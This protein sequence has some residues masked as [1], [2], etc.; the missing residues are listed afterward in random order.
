MRGFFLCTLIVSLFAP[1]FAQTK[2][3]F[4]FED[5]MKLKRVGEPEVSPD[6]KWVLFSVVDVDLDANTQ[7]PHIWIVPTG[8]GQEREIIA[9]QDAD[10]PRW[11]PDGKRFAFISNKEGGSQ[12]WIAD[13][14]AGAGTVTGLHKLTSI[15]T[16][17]DGELWS[18]D[19]KNILFVSNIYPD[20]PDEACNARKLEEAAK[21]KVKAI[22]FTRLLF[23]HLYAYKEG[24]RSHIFVIAV[25]ACAGTGAPFCPADAARDLTPGDYDA[26]VFSF[27]QDEYAFSPDGREICYTSNHDKNE[28]ASTNSDLWIV[29]IDATVI[30]SGQTVYRQ[31]PQAKNITADNLASDS[32]PL[33]SPDGRYI[34]YRAQQRPGYESDRLRLTL[35]DRKTGEKKN[36]TDDFDRWVGTFA[37]APDSKAIYFTAEDKGDSPV[38]RVSLETPNVV[39]RIV[40]LAGR[41]D[42]PGLASDGKSL[43][44]T[45]E[46]LKAPAEIY[47]ADV[48]EGNLSQGASGT[49]QDNR[50][51]DDGAVIGLGMA[52]LTHFNETVLSQ[53]AMSPLESFWFTGA[54]GDK[55][56]GFLVKPPDFDASKTYPLKFFLKG[57]PQIA[58][59][60][61]WDYGWNFELLA[62]NGYVVITIN[63]HGSTGYG[64]KFIDAVT[65]DWGGAPF[66]DEMKGLDYAEKT[67]P[68]IDKDREC[69]IGSSYGGFMA[70]WVLGHTYRFKCIV[71]H[72][73]VFNAEAFWGSTDELW[74]PDWDFKGTP[75]DDHATYQ[76][77]SPHRYAR[78]FKT[79]TLVIHGQHDYRADV[80]QSFQLFTTLQTLGVPSKM[81]YFPDEAQYPQQPQNSQLF[82]KTVN[83]WVDQWTK[84]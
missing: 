22:I 40:S 21:S 36:L 70:N 39:S 6:G 32:T 55:I 37:W 17:A 75:Y 78:N 59:G 71:S 41:D 63:F 58:W 84:K 20:C 1:A 16:E 9:D 64:Q 7:T 77:W 30:A 46:S 34:A 2:H 38:Y 83:D 60:D 73:S 4:T 45:H 74:Y 49:Q 56:E 29:P 33:Y 50:I 44:F 14:D 27:G 10:R 35:Y 79:P 31:P 18:P 80:S 51:P 53:V 66:E 26:P 82:Y 19:G 23:R 24:K 15:A 13:I 52:Q 61:L 12:V 72:H 11:A 25:D 47:R 5:M 48:A 62:A 3:A 28:A 54:H 81:L 65:G 76:K 8:G 57:G 67:Y 42:D 43:F 69:A 68:F